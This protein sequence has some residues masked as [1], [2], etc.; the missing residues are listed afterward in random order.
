MQWDSGTPFSSNNGMRPGIPLGFD[1][2]LWPNMLWWLTIGVGVEAHVIHFALDVQVLVE[3]P[4]IP[5]LVEACWII[6]FRCTDDSTW[7]MARAFVIQQ[8]E[9]RSHRDA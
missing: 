4:T 6:N 2:Q 3:S 5:A 9:T 8:A 1:A 7:T